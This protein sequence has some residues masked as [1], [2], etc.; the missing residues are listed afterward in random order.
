MP[1]HDRTAGL[2]QYAVCI[3]RENDPELRVPVITVHASSEPDAV[4]AART[5]YPAI[6]DR[7]V[8]VWPHPHGDPLAATLL[9]G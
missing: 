7:T 4:A 6:A 2:R 1:T 8:A 3:E 5:F 9:T